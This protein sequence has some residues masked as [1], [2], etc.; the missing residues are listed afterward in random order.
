MTQRIALLLA[1]M[2]SPATAASV[3]VENAWIRAPL[4]GLALTAAYCDIRNDGDEAV[5]VVGFDGPVRVEMH[6]TRV[7]SGIAKMRPLGPLRIAAKATARLAPGGKHLMLFGMDA[8]RTDSVTLRV[9]LANGERIAAV[10]PVRSAAT[11]M[12]DEAD[13]SERGDVESARP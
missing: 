6:E 4:A 8:L 11:K 9:Q 7:E 5:T 2:A 3:V 10:F 1:L 12:T 13:A